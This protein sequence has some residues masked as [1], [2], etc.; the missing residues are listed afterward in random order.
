MANKER[1]ERDADRIRRANIP[2]IRDV[3]VDTRI[4]SDVVDSIN[5]HAISGT[6]V[7]NL[8]KTWVATPKA[9]IITNTH[10]TVSPTV[11]FYWER[12]A[13]PSPLYILYGVELPTGSSI[14]LDPTDLSID[15]NATG[16]LIQLA[17]ASGTPTVQ[18]RVKVE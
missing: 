18:V 1:I 17:A 16:L 9:V 6:G 5:V 15:S 12:S 14:V 2:T 7:N 4:K 13:S 3:K 8:G 11:N 10:D